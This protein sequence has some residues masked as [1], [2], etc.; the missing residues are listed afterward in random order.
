[1]W[2]RGRGLAQLLK[3]MVLMTDRRV[4]VGKNSRIALMAQ[5]DTSGGGHIHLGHRCDVH[6]HAILSTN[7]GFVE[8]GDDCSVNPFAVLYGH[9]GLSIGNGVRIAAHAVLIPANHLTQAHAPIFTQG[10]S[11]KGIR[12]ADDVWIGAGA[13]VLDG[14]ELA[15]GSVVAAGAV[16]SRNTEAF[17]IYAGVPAR[18]I[19]RRQ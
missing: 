18:A 6:S 2:S 12:V 10:L 14:V 16:V 17:G 1:M 11:K 8:L 7:G 9:G 4:S 3:R 15:R 13:V 19:G 5:L